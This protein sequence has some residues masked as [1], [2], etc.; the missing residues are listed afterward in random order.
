MKPKELKVDF[1]KFVGK[2]VWWTGSFQNKETELW[3]TYML[4]S[5]G[6]VAY[7]PDKDADEDPKTLEHG[8]DVLK[9]HLVDHMP[10]AVN[11]VKLQNLMDNSAQF[12]ANKT[13]TQARRE[14]LAAQG[15]PVAAPGELQGPTPTQE[16][17][18]IE[19]TV[20]DATIPPAVQP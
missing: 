15:V 16:V 1:S 5:D 14:H 17:K 3:E 12:E 20:A 13:A 19:E 7:F 9:Q 11:V 2:E 6:T 10:Y 18:A 8:L 4:F